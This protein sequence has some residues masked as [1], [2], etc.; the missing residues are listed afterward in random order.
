MP[1]N[2]VVAVLLFEHAIAPFEIFFDFYS[3]A[4]AVFTAVA[5][6]KACKPHSPIRMDLLEQKTV[7][8]QVQNFAHKAVTV[9][10]LGNAIT[11]GQEHALSL[12]FKNQGFVY[13]YAKMLWEKISVGK[14]M[15]PL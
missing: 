7:Q 11:V 12:N 1:V 13:S 2:A 15:V 5:P 14:I 6:D 9:I 3:A 8:G 10:G 4:F